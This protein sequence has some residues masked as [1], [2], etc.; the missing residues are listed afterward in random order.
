MVDR[1]NE[2]TRELT[3]CVRMQPSPMEVT[4][5]TF[6]RSSRVEIDKIKGSRFIARGFVFSGEKSLAV[7]IGRLREEFREANHHCYAWRDGERFRH[8]DDGEPS[9]SAGKPILQQIDGGNLDRVAIVVTR[10]FGGTKLGVGGLIRAYGAAAR[11]LIASAEIAEVIPARIVEVTIPY[12]MSGALAGI[13]NTFGVTP[14]ESNFGERARQTFRIP[15]DNVDAFVTALTNQ[16]AG[17]A[18]IAVTNP[19]PR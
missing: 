2:S 8:G 14:T 18:E 10:I 3:D 7:E 11:E 5:R 12:E 17:R 1:V 6:A 4:Y 16:T 9:G 15:L 13:A 19:D